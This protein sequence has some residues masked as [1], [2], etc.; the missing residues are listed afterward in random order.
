[1]IGSSMIGDC[2]QTALG[3]LC[4]AGK[5]GAGDGDWA[6]RWWPQESVFRCCE[7]MGKRLYLTKLHHPYY[8]FGLRKRRVLGVNVDL[9]FLVFDA[10]RRSE[11]NK[12]ADF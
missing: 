7:K 6:E 11:L 4:G 1:M 3:I 8:P 2:R 10:G 12:G 9:P 5:G